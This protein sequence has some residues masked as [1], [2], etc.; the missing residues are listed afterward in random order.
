MLTINY[1][2]KDYKYEDDGMWTEGETN[3]PVSE[4]LSERLRSIATDSGVTNLVSKNDTVTKPVTLDLKKKS[5]KKSRPA[6][7]NT[8]KIFDN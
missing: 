4:E 2:G 1:D 5:V 8:V 7:K 6:K 3:S